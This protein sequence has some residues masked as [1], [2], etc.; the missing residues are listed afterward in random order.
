[1]S[2]SN[3]GFGLPAPS[4]GA[5]P[6]E[7]PDTTPDRKLRRRLIF[8][9][10]IVAFAG[11]A[12][13]F[14]RGLTR[15]PSLVPSAL[16]GKPVPRFSLPPVKGRALGLS[17]ADLRGTVSLVNV[18]ASWCVACREE[19]PIWMR[20]K[21][22]GIVPIHGLN[23]KDQPDDAARWLDTFG[24]PY[25]RTGADVDGRVAIDWGVY[26]VP[27]TYLVDRDGRIVFKQIGAVNARV[28]DET[29]LPLIVRV[30]GAAPSQAGLAAPT[31]KR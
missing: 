8:G 23:Y 27:E 26:G 9:I 11:L 24:D 21:Q 5:P 19:H 12:L 6:E 28:L 16:I 10:P 4:A 29:L 14:G 31:E 20:L 30:R 2:D 13:A 15:D 7:R 18:F 1:M 3:I 22:E 17:D 25:T